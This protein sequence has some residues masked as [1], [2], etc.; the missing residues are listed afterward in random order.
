MAETLVEALCARQKDGGG[1][2][3][4]FLASGAPPVEQ[5]FDQ[6][7]TLA[8]AQA[9]A[10]RRAGLRRGDRV[11]LMLRSNLE[12]VRMLL[13][14]FAGGLVPVP[15]YSP[16]SLK[17]IHLYLGNLANILRVASPSALIVLPEVRG[18]LE[19]VRGQLPGKAPVWSVDQLL[20]E[21]GEQAFASMKPED[22]ALIQFS[23]GSTGTPKGSLITHGNFI[24]NLRAIASRCHDGTSD[25]CCS[26]LPLFHDMGLMA[27]LRPL[28]FNY[29]F[30]LMEPETFLRKPSRWL[31]AISDY[32]GT[33]TGC[34]NFAFDLCTR[35][36]ADDE[37]EGVSLASWRLASNGA[38]PIRSDVTEAFCQRFSRWGFRR[39][40]MYP[41]YGLS[42]FTLAA[43]LP[44]I[45]GVVLG[46][47]FSR[48][49]L[50][51]GKRAVALEGATSAQTD[52]V[53]LAGLGSAP[54]GH[55]L[56]IL[57]SDRGSPHPLPEGQVGEVVLTG[58]SLSQGYFNA[59]GR[60]A[61]VFGPWVDGDA[62]RWFRTGDEG[63]VLQGQLYVTG[64]LD[65]VM[66]VR[67]RN[68]HPQDIEAIA[69]TV[70]GV[71]PGCT[72]AIQLSAGPRHG[73]VVLV[74]ESKARVDSQ[75]LVKE[76]RSRVHAALGVPLDEVVW[77]PAGTIPKTSSGKICRNITRK[78]LE[79][80]QWVK[81]QA[82]DWLRGALLQARIV[83]S[84]T[85]NRLR[86]LFQRSETSP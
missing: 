60:T 82:P 73:R 37:L 44:E 74:A 52:G 47:R 75:Q 76:V 50:E 20:P 85:R 68:L 55:D 35:K 13:G 30:V 2:R 40:T 6:L 45:G 3:L 34:P 15:L 25:T 57:A 71:R 38:E 18:V 79:E 22:P 23:S 1:S 36:V 53:S 84:R 24:A 58:P 48:E 70:P 65:D 29:P 17:R 27:F 10:F 26:W 46:R 86:F 31:R 12:F 5:P 28:Y 11:V 42:E 77:I 14:A 21:P 78:Q 8:A 66:I 51:G 32:R 41:C 81:R 49:A 33:I 43:T 72:A 56:R 63:F 16:T 62:R 83:L 80:G 67:G 4:S 64:R 19:L 59:P 7:A 69:E 39:E 9:A 54:P 61:E